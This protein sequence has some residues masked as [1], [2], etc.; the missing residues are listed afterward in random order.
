MSRLRGETVRASNPGRTRNFSLLQ[1][2][3]PDSL[4]YLSTYSVGTEVKA[5]GVVKLRAHLDLVPRLRANG[6]RI[7]LHLCGRGKLYILP[8]GCENSVALGYF[9]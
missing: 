2:V 4:I 5:A 9:K 3:H 8:W 7:P 6:A 1:L